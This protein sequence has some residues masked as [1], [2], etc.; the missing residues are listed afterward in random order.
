MRRSTRN[1]FKI[2]SNSRTKISSIF[3]HVIFVISNE[4]S[5]VFLRATSFISI[6]PEQKK[7]TRDLEL[8][9]TFLFYLTKRI[10]SN[11]LI[12]FRL[13]SSSPRPCA[14]ISNFEIRGW[15]FARS[16]RQGDPHVACQL[17][18]LLILQRN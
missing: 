10:K 6:D 12:H 3:L 1:G 8:N 15:K 9:R 18:V 5:F 17:V 4:S 13:S 16:T 14:W 7:E 2:S 11:R